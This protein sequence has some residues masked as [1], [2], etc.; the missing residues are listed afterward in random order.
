MTRPSRRDFVASLAA[1]AAAQN[2]RNAAG[3][4]MISVDLQKLISRGD[5]S[6]TKPA[7]RSEEGIPVGNGRMGTL[8]WTTPTDL[9]M[10]INRPDVYP[11]NSETNS[12]N[13][14]HNDYCGGCAFVDVQVAGAGAD[15]FP[16]SGFAQ[17][18]SIY[19]GKLAITGTGVTCNVVAWP[20]QDVIALQITDNR[21]VPEA[22]QVGLR[23]LRYETKHYGAALAK[24][25]RENITA[26]QTGSHMALSQVAIQ[27]GRIALTQD[28]QEGTYRNKSAVV[29][30]VVGRTAKPRLVHEG[31]VSL[32]M[33]AAKGSFTIL[34]ASAATFAADEDIA[35]TAVRQLQAGATKSFDA[36]AR[37]TAEWWRDFWSRSFVHV[38]NPEG[39]GDL[40]Q[41]HY[42]YFQ[43]L[44][45]AS[46]RG[47]FPPKFNG[48]IWNT[49]GDLRAWGAQHWYANLS[50]YYEAIPATN[51]YELM[52][53]VFDM[54]FGAREACTTAAA[55]QWGSRG[56]YI[57]ETMWFDGLAKLPEAIA[58]EM[59]ELYLLQKPW[60]QM[61]AAFREHSRQKHPHSSR[62][63]WIAKREWVD[64]RIV[65][66][67]RGSGPYGATNH[68]FGTSAKIPYLFWR[69]YEYTL[70]RDWLRDRAYPMLKGAA[71]FYRNYPKLKKGADGKYHIHD[72]NSNESVW[73]AQDTDEDLSSM[74]GVFAVAIRAAE[75]LDVDGELRSTWKE[76]LANLPALPTSDHP[77]ALKTDGYAG[78]T[79]YVRGLKPAIKPGMLPDGNSLPAWLFDL[80]NLES[81]DKRAL[82]IANNTI[83]AALRGRVGP[84]TPVGLLSKVP[85]AAATLGRAEDIRYLIA[86]QMRGL[87]RPGSNGPATANLANRMSLREG[88]QALDA[89][90]LGR[91]SEA[92]HLALLQS[93]PPAPGE[94]P[95]IRV[96]PAW[97]KDWEGSFTLLARG[98]FLVTSSMRAGRVD[99]LEL[100]SQAGAPC[101][102]RNP[103]GEGAVALH[104]D[105]AKAETLSGPLLRFASRKGE[106]IV[107][108]PDGTSLDSVKRS[109]A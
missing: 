14:R 61:T 50:C 9:R 98:A 76:V 72:V 4:S 23:V 6:Y 100:Q 84:T 107:L 35:A 62:W 22:V 16:E 74:K 94:A 92:L 45:G 34:I 93:G 7:S 24:F 71:E 91:A 60:E 41:Q 15:A 73:G 90:A 82:E 2:V 63:N 26:V 3:S 88:P 49:G 10:Q 12:F 21:A 57:P 27:D 109:V 33:P 106:R 104:R 80:C 37:E 1:S 75:T 20:V 30:G 89:Q 55:Q 105:S 97:P 69:R 44:M 65:D 36:L 38:R 19:D 52:D 8:V 46:S 87:P 51:R 28:F 79:V 102:V 96:F 5:L 68:I 77:D 31:E 86:N 25:Q 18:L 32:A 99:F 54:Y 83:T 17:K 85:M 11:N 42:L 78:P 29:I 95:V 40:I 39:T 56:A 13:E 66:T 101:I 108:V 70:D 67:E 59:R 43:Y 81:N 47:K 103:W 64:G 53:P 58:T 48:M